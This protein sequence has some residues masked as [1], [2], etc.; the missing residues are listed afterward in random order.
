MYKIIGGDGQEY[1]PVTEAELR[2]WI[3]EGRLSAQS[4][5]KGENDADFRPLSTFPEFAGALGITAGAYGGPAPSWQSV[6]WSNRDYELDIGGCISRGWN[7]FANNVGILVGSC[8]LW[9]VLIFIMSA[10]IGGITAAIVN[11]AFPAEMR[12][13]SAFQI[14]QSYVLK[15]V[16]ALLL[17]PL[18]GGLYYIYIQT[19]R[20]RPCGIGDLFLGFQR[21]Y[22]QL[23]LGFL[24]VSLAEAVCFLPSSIFIMPRLMPLLMLMQQTQH[25][26][27]SQ[28][29]MQEK[30]QQI[31]P[32]MISALGGGLPIFLLCL[33]PWFYL[34]TNFL[35]VLP[36]IID[37]GVD[38]WT[39][40]KTSWKMAHKHW[41]TVFGLGFL[42]LIIGFAGG[43]LCCIGVFFTFAIA[44]AATLFGYET[45]FGESQRV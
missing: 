21:A 40:I 42:S 34:F 29:E 17:G 4:L 22:P 12:L 15:V 38:F 45:I 32:Q 10:V 6:D 44:T 37:K 11:G 39:A 24:V 7:L 25:S 13:S 43:F 5:A 19:M 27:A 2:K 30:M 23:F 3:A 16:M 28:A 18:T 8:V 36:L 41:F 14:I 33:I 31:L 1:G 20:S 26:G 35:F 9:F